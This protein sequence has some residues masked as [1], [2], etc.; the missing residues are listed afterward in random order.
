MLE[1][2]NIHSQYEYGQVSQA[3]CGAINILLKEY[4]LLVTQLDTE[5]MKGD[6]TLQKIWYFVQ[7]SA[8]IMENLH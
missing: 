7:P 2:V 8:R 5:F 3:L 1:F 4:M 6:L